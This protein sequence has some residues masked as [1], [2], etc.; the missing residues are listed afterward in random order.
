MS[1]SLG[2]R[3]SSLKQRLMDPNEGRPYIE[4]SDQDLPPLYESVNSKDSDDKRSP[5]SNIN[6]TLLPFKAFY[7][8]FYGAVGSLFPFIALYFR[9]LWLSPTQAGLL[10]GLRPIVQSVT[11]PFW[12]LFADRF[13]AKKIVLF[14]GLCGWLFSHTSLLLVPA[15][16]KPLSCTE[17]ATRLVKRS[18]DSN[19]PMSDNVFGEEP[20]NQYPREILDY[21]PAD[22]SYTPKIPREKL[23]RGSHEYKST[24]SNVNVLQRDDT[25]NQTSEIRNRSENK[26]SEGSH[27]TKNQPSASIVDNMNSEF[28]D[29]TIAKR[30]W[31][32]ISTN[33]LP[34]DT[35]HTFTYLFLIILFGNL[36]AAPAQTMANTATLQVLDDETHKYGAQRYF[37]SIG[38]GVTAFVV[39]ML[40]SLNH[41]S[42]LACKGLDDINYTP[43]FYAFGVMMLCS[44]VVAIPFK[45]RNETD[46]NPSKSPALLSI[47]QE[48]NYLTL[49]VFFAVFV[50]GFNMGFIQTFLFWHLQSLGG[51]QHLFSLIL[52]FNAVGEMVGFLLSVKL[53]SKYGHLKVLALGMF[54]YAVRLTMYGVVEN[55]WLVLTVEFLKAFTSSAVWSSAMSYIGQSYP[56]GSSV[57]AVVHML[58]WGIGYGGGGMLGGVLMDQI[59]AKTVFLGLAIIS[60]VVVILTLVIV[61]LNCC[62]K[63]KQDVYMPVESDDDDDEED[64]D[65]D[66]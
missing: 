3:L 32:S 21:N 1:E 62:T 46:V 13:N 36:F 45:F 66:E 59:G 7:F 57:S 17:N 60:L 61:H 18:I 52:G 63:R 38:W 16:K 26:S 22:V 11:T 34:L 40:V 44:L 58:Y 6:R 19:Y 33:H 49:F 37:G 50:A 12:A 2:D 47:C 39:G 29:K 4:T 55:P 64:Q 43:C 27:K 15:G 56:V 35:W 30:S 9:H 48:Q 5:C 23:P 54:A 41:D 24:G 51:T 53:I 25:N 65:S 10:V 14:I 20:S 8:F 42:S 31:W 28:A